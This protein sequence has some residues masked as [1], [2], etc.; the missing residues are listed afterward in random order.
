[1]DGTLRNANAFREFPIA[2]PH[3]AI[4][5]LLFGCQ[6]QVYQEADRSSVMADQVAHEHVN[7]VLVKREHR[8]I[9]E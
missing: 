8:Y 4:S 1:L 6:P 7:N 3:H 9:N 5:A 2:D